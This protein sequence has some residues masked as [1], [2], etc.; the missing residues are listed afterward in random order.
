MKATKKYENGGKSKRDGSKAVGTAT[1][2]QPFTS[3]KVRSETRG[4]NLSSGDKKRVKKDLTNSLLTPKDQAP[5]KMRRLGVKKVVTDKSD[6]DKRN[7]GLKYEG[8]GKY[9]ARKEAM[10]RGLE[11]KIKK[12]KGTPA[13]KPL[14]DQYRKLTG[15]K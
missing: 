8:G 4:R 3:D 14:V 6:L 15:T 11:A 1:G 9:D 13:A 10:K 2:N 5:P 7:R 12:A